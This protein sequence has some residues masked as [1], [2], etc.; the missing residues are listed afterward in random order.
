MGGKPPQPPTLPKDG[1]VKKQKLEFFKV[2]IFV[3]STKSISRGKGQSAVASASYR[4]GVELQDERYGK[5]HDYSK[6]HGVM[7]ADIILPSLLKG[8]GVTIERNELWNKAEKAENRKDAR[9]GREWLINLPYELDEQ[10]R[11]ELA[12][13]FSQELADRYGVIADCAIHQPTQK[14]IE[15]GA[16]ARNFHAHIMLTTR[17]AELNENNE[18]VL[19][20]KSTAELSDKK[21]RELGLERMSEEIKEVR[22]LWESVANKKLAEHNLNLIDS[23]SYKARGLDII[24][25]IKMGVDA[26]HLERRTGIKSDKGIINDIIKERNELVFNLESRQR[27]ERE[28]A[29]DR[30]RT[31]INRATRAT[32]WTDKAVKWADQVARWTDKRSEQTAKTSEWANDRIE[33]VNRAS[34]WADNRT[35]KIN[36]AI[37][38][39]KQAVD[40][41]KQA[42]TARVSRQ[43]PSPFDEQYRASINRRKQAT[44]EL[45]EQQRRVDTETR[46]ANTDARQHKYKDERVAERVATIKLNLANR[47]LIRKKDEMRVRWEWYETTEE[48]PNK[49]DKRQIEILDHFE[50]SLNIETPHYREKL[51]HIRDLMNDEFIQEHSDIINILKDPAQERKQY[52][53]Q[54]NA[55][56]ANWLKFKESLDKQR[57]QLH[58]QLKRQLGNGGEVGRMT[59]E[60]L[61]AVSYLQAVDSFINDDSQNADAR[62]L[63]EKHK[64]DTLSKTCE[65]FRLSYYDVLKLRDDNERNNYANALNSSL[66]SF[67]RS[68]GSELSESQNKDINSGLYSFERDIQYSSQSNRLSR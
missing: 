67:K 25:Q 31:A 66:E 42:I 9:V 60:T 33:R 63:A 37:D 29:N 28:Q 11:K 40:D 56:I 44:A 5:K 65:Q 52:T 18:I 34:Q 3:A 55:N 43:R 57:E 62:Q 19:T 27:N 2:S 39:S 38:D 51:L 23:R 45:A 58:E 35:A 1:R 64:E 48:Y 24:P 26:T 47:L 41:S 15:R 10:E 36:K 17:Q 16:D 13:T 49:F 12:H 14:E 46:R 20:K 8:A 7:S 68:Y 21:R 61:T 6:R 54:Y 4:A 50:K 53:E 30:L 32:R 59:R 22:K